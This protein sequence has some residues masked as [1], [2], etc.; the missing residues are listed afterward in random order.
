MCVLNF[1]GKRWSETLLC[2]ACG[3]VG[4][5]GGGVLWPGPGGGALESRAFWASGCVGAAP[6]V[7]EG[8]GAWSSGP[9]GS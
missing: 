2:L 7:E 4:G 6:S 3:P 1:W 5:G 9:T 8:V